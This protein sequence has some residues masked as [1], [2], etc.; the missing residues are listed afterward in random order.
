MKKYYLATFIIFFGLL[1]YGQSN[2]VTIDRGTVEPSATGSVTGISSIGLTTSAEVDLTGNTDF[3]TRR[4]DALTQAEAESLGEYIEWSLTADPDFAVT[5]DGLDIRVTRNTNGPQSWQIFYSLD[6]FVTAGTALSAAQ[7][8][9]TVDDSSA[10]FSV[11][12]LGVSI[13]DQ[14]TITFRLYAWNNAGN[15]NNGRLQIAGNTAWSEFGIADPGVRLRG[16]ITSTQADA[17][18]DIVR[19]TSFTEPENIDYLNFDA[20]S[21][22]TTSNALKIGEFTIRDGGASG[23]DTDGLA[24]TLTDISFDISNSGFIAALAIFD[25]GTPVAEVTSVT[26]TTNFSGLTLSALENSSKSFEV[27]ATFTSSVTDNEQFQLTVSSA[28]ADNNGSDFEQTNAGG[29]ATSIT[30]D[31]NRIEVLATS[32]LYIQNTSDVSLFSPMTPAVTLRAVDGNSNQDLDYSDVVSVFTSGTFDAEATTSVNAVGGLVTFSNLIFGATGTGINIT[33]FATG[34]LNTPSDLFDVV[35]LRTNIFIQD[36]DGGSPEWTFVNSQPTYDSG[37]G[38]GGYYGTIDVSAATPLNNGNFNNNIW[39]ENI[40]GSNQPV[41]LTFSTV[42][43]TGRTGVEIIF[44]WQVSGYADNRNDITYTVTID[45]VAQTPVVLFDGSPGNTEGS[46]TEIIA[47]P[48]GSTSVSIDIEHDNR[49]LTGYS[50]FDNVRIEAD[51]NGLIYRNSVWTPNPPSE[52]TATDDALISNG[53]YTISSPI[54]VNNF[55]VDNGASVIVD[56]GQTFIT[57]GNLAN[58][59]EITLNSTSLLFSSIIPNAVT[60]NGTVNYSRFVNVVGT[61]GVNGGNDLISLPLMTNTQTFDEFITFGSPANSTILAT[62]GVFYA[63]APFNRSTNAYENFTVAGTDALTRGIGYRVATTLGENLSFIGDIVTSDVTGIP[64]SKPAGGSQWNLIGNPYPSYVSSA[65]FITANSSVMDPTATAIYGYNSGTGASSGSG[66]LGNFTVIN[67]VT[68]TAN[69]AP[70]QGFFIAVDNTDGFSGT[71]DFTASMR[72]ID[73]DNDFILTRTSNQ[74]NLNVR[75][76]LSNNNN[77]RLTDFYFHPNGTRGLDPGYDAATFGSTLGGFELYS[78]LVEDTTGRSMM[79]QTL[80]MDDLTDVRVPL[81]VNASQGQQISFAIDYSNIPTDIEVILEDT[82]S[83]TYTRLGASDYVIT[84]S[85]TLSGTGRFYLNFGSNSLSTPERDLINVRIYGVYNKQ[86]HIEGQ[87]EFDTKVLVYDLQG[88]LVI[89]RELTTHDTQH[90]I[91]ASQLHSSIY[92]VKL[93][94][95]N[96]EHTVKIILK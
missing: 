68:S 64:V 46:G 84:T 69:V 27:Y 65:D 38:I 8:T 96:S 37:W 83:N 6:G 47:I 54:E 3:E 78:M 86:I 44:D 40:T 56:P 1:C 81:G 5:F 15:P 53:T 28:I 34:I 26:A 18:S 85:S 92:L 10:D 35:S 91:D 14:G 11:S 67:A 52:A 48:D 17:N 29:A 19:S 88:R 9:S 22:L 59:G 75:L 39:G 61:T 12:G 79:V 76:K 73:G 13:P 57:N 77:D 51:Y 66:S 30:G 43:V 89:Q 60:T 2:L 72:T 4:W 63:F 33:A 62:N 36:F 82:E 94:N 23:I 74:E 7:T 71:V 49:L 95:G 21:G 90:T 41:N 80:G 58:N 32:L 25:N 20:A 45:N 93:D 24:T 31:A 87:L 55:T 16:S 42:D 50:G 70:G